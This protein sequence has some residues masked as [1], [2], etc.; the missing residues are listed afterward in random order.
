MEGGSLRPGRPPRGTHQLYRR[1]LLRAGGRERHV[2]VH[3]PGT[4]LF[5]GGRAGI[6]P[7]GQDKADL[8]AG[9]GIP[10]GI[11]RRV[12]RRRQND[13]FGRQYV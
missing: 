4:G 12:R 7:G 6:H 9:R 11:R 13:L 5:P 10:D 1:L 2:H 3:V 8:P